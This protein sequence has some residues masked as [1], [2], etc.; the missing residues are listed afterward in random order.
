M[1]RRAMGQLVFLLVGLVVFV[2]RCSAYGQGDFVPTS[3]KGQ[4]HNMRTDWMD[5]LGRHC[6]R[7]GID[8][9][10]VLPLPKPTGY[11]GADPYKISLQFGSERYQT[12]WLFVVGRQSPEV[13]MID[14]T[15][16]YA[17]SDFLGATAKVVNMPESYLKE[18]ASIKTNFW[19]PNMWPKHVLVRYVWEESSEIDVAGGLYVLFGSGLVL[20]VAMALHILQSS[21]E[22]L[23]RFIKETVVD[24]A[25]PAEE[26]KVE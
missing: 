17:G 7:F 3:R 13:P 24:S 6:P 2:D 5:Q 15:L 23:S 14:V 8:N 21:K 10:V 19:E 11:T 9:E 1:S 12:P 4:Y 18:H 25:M 22:K 26:A 16:R 20:T